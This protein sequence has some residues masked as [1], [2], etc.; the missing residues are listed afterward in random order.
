VVN[1]QVQNTPFQP[2]FCG[3]PLLTLYLISRINILKIKT[4]A[5]LAIA[6]TKFTAFSAEFYKAFLLDNSAKPSDEFIALANAI[7]EFEA[8]PIVVKRMTPEQDM[9]HSLKHATN[10]KKFIKTETPPMKTKSQQFREYAQRL[11]SKAI[12]LA[13][14]QSSVDGILNTEVINGTGLSQP[15]FDEVEIGKAS[16][17]SYSRVIRLD[18]AQVSHKAEQNG[19]DNP[20]DGFEQDETQSYEKPTVQHSVVKVK[21]Q[22]SKE[23]IADV[24]VDLLAD[25]LASIEEGERELISYELFNGV[26]STGTEPELDGIN[27]IKSDLANDFAECL[28][29]DATRDVNYY[30]VALSGADGETGLTVEAKIDNLIDLIASLPVLYK[31]R[32]KFYMEPSEKSD[33][34]KLRDSSGELIFNKSDGLLLGYPVVEI[35]HFRA[36]DELDAPVNATDIRV[37]FGHLESAIEVDKVAPQNGLAELFSDEFSVDGAL[38]IKGAKTYISFTKSNKALRLLAAKA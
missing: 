11:A 12:S 15:V 20:S 24:H 26:G 3:S 35:E 33:Y 4:Y 14:V 28:K 36:R 16:S 32:A 2:L 17:V 27:T 13:G 38:L 21:T 8:T 1:L 5:E 34:M 31:S 22:V 23:A 29:S 6:N 30:S 7:D 9:A 18:N 25:T 10:N 19:T 37:A